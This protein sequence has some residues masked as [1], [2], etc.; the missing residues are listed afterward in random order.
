MTFDIK[1]SQKNGEQDKN[2]KPGILNLLSLAYTPWSKNYQL[3]YP[4]V[5]MTYQSFNISLFRIC[6]SPDTPKAIYAYVYCNALLFKYKS[7]N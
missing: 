7:N 5:F 2:V 4:Q 3:G 1:T 6:V